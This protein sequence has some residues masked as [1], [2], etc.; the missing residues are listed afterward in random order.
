MLAGKALASVTHSMHDLSMGILVQMLDIPA[1]KLKL[2]VKQD[3]T[4]KV[5]PS[6]VLASGAKVQGPVTVAKLLVNLAGPQHSE[7][8]GISEVEKVKVEEQMVFAG[9]LSSRLADKDGWAPAMQ[10]LNQNLMTRVFFATN[11]FTLADIFLYSTLYLPV[12]KLNKQGRLTY[13]HVTRY[14]DLVQHLCHESGKLKLTQLVEID[15]N[16]PPDVKPVVEK[17]KDKAP[18]AVKEDAASDA[19]AASKKEKKGDKSDGASADNK[20]AEGGKKEKAAVADTTADAK[21][22]KKKKEDGDATPALESK[23]EPER[24][25]L[26]VGLIVTA[27]RHPQADAL[28]VEEV[29]L[30]EGTNRTVVSG[31]VKWMPESDLQG[32]LVV[33]LCNL[34]PAKMRG[35]ESQAMVLCT[36]AAD[37]SKVELLNAP[38]GSKPGDRC[39]FDNYHGTD[40]SQLNPKKKIWEGVQPC[41]KTDSSRRAVFVVEQAGVKHVSVLRTDKGEVTC[42]SVAGGSIK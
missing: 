23:P 25:D 21:A 28:Y 37:G 22:D 14:F 39:W 13:C 9:G 12:S 30:G 27:Q 41:L 6:A 34:K 26:R 10:E 17:K 29:D 40:F 35:I 11:Y 3:P 7:W 32:K 38:A 24:L 31:L 4:D 33:L 20:K 2:A 1:S 36:T 18:S 8:L 5:V 16:A 15:L 42:A 19:K